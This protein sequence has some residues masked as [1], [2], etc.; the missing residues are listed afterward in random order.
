M[1]PRAGVGP[2]RRLSGYAADFKSGVATK[3]L[4]IQTVKL[5]DRKISR[6]LKICLRSAR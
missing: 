4:A 5:V 6:S 3:A 2:A 1:V